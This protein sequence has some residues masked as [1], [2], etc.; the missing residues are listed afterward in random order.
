MEAHP[1]HHTRYVPCPDRGPAVF[2]VTTVTICLATLFVAGRM[3]SRIG[4]VRRVGWDDYIIVFAWLMAMFLSATIDMATR[5]GLGR[6]DGD[7][8]PQDLPRLRMWEYVFS[9]LYNPALMATKTSILVFYLR[10]AKHTQKVLRMASWAVLVVVNVAGTILTF[11]NIFQCTPTRAAWDITVESAKCL[12]LLTEFICSSP[13]NIVTDLAVLALPIPVL[14]GMRLPPRQKTILIFTFTLGIFVTV[15]DVVRI[16]YLQQAVGMVAMS[17]S[18]DPSAIY[19]QSSNFHWNASLS[20]M[21]SAVEVNVG[22][23]CACIPTLKPLIIRILPAMIIDPDGTRS[24]TRDSAQLV[25]A[26]FKQ[27]NSDSSQPITFS[28]LNDSHASAPQTP[29]QVHVRNGRLSEEISFRD[30]LS[31]SA[32]NEIPAPEGRMPTLPDR[33]RFSSA[34]ENSIYFG[35]VE[36]KKPKSMVKSSVSESLKYCTIVSILFFLWGFSYGLLNTLNNVVANVAHMTTAQA[37][38]LTS[39]Y[40][41]GGYFLGPL[42][43]GGWLLS[44]DEHRRFRRRRRGDIEPIGG[45]KATFIVGLLIYGVGTIMFWP[46]AV[47]ASYSGFMASSFVVGFG[48]A[49]LETAANPFLVLCGPPEYADMRLLLAQGIQATGAVLSGVLANNVFF[50]KIEERRHSPTTLLDVQ[51]TYLTITLLC[52]LLALFFYYS[53]LPEVTDRELGRLS[54]RLPIDPKKRSIGGL[55]LRTWCILLAVFSQWFYVAGQENMSVYFTR[56]MTAFSST[57]EE[58]PDS[59]PEGF[60]ISTLHY[61][62]VSH[63]AFSTSR[64]ISAYLCYLH[65]KHP[66]SRFIPTPR[67]I[68]NVCT[69]L[70]TVFILVTVVYKA[71]SNP[72]FMVIPIIFFFFFEGPI[73]PLIFSLGMRGQGKRTKQT[74]AWLTM[75]GSGPAF[76]PFVSYAILQRGGSI[77]TS[78]IVGIVLMAMTMVYPIFLTVVRDAREMSDHVM[79]TTPSQKRRRSGDV[80]SGG[81]GLVS[82]CRVS[83]MSMTID[84]IIANRQKEREKAAERAARRAENG[85]ALKRLSTCLGIG[86]EKTSNEDTKEEKRKSQQQQQQRTEVQFEKQQWGKSSGE[87][88]PRKD[89]G[90][91]EEDHVS[92]HDREGQVDE[93]T[94][95]NPTPEWERQMAPWELPQLELDT[96]ILED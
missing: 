26:G 23:I 66:T 4:I 54:E 87:D 95:P 30:F 24:S 27:D 51:W 76:W 79:V 49:V 92:G 89:P 59:R 12:P 77:Q 61:L 2:V 93:V 82:E 16:Y 52:V 58:Y 53:P 29:E 71:A 96:R 47:L 42:L 34:Q 25:D 43:V 33:R 86:T 83:E 31:A 1:H 62:V 8:H 19:G 68:L 69:V 32:L 14:T 81:V 15:V 91:Q 72:N 50:H 88:E 18:D 57:H 67:T 35:F 7:I 74:A 75:G 48:L 36:M 63:S 17:A 84:Q 38:G 37:L 73:W 41:G 40:F 22:I 56:L 11:M 80:E 45:F 55:S 3:V 9:I 60:E 21:W 64:F 90:E 39:V 94:D 44:H 46:C 13:V 10:L 28:T 70:S 65:K 6:H 5:R 78:F 85:G 20:L